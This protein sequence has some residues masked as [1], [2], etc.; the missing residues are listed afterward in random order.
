M[1]PET[2]SDSGDILDYYL[3][4]DVAPGGRFM[5]TFTTQIPKAPVKEPKPERDN[6]YGWGMAGGGMLLAAAGGAGATVLAR[7]RRKHA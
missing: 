7:K 2:A 3:Y 4:G 1:A 5:F 6:S